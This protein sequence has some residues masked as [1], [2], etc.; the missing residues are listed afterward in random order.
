MRKKYIT[1]EFEQLVKIL[2]IKLEKQ[3]IKYM[4]TKKSYRKT[5]K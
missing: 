5:S 3:S 4:E 2:P 1:K